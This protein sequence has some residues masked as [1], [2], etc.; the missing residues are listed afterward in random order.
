M[1]T[2]TIGIIQLIIGIIL[3][4]PAIFCLVAAASSGFLEDVDM[5]YVLF[6]IFAILTSLPN[7]KSS[8]SKSKK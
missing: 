7:L 8:T 2:K 3:A 5:L 1:K 6:A 4:V